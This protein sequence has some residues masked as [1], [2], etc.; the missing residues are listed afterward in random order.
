MAWKKS[1]SHQNYIKIIVIPLTPLWYFFD[2]AL[3]LLFYIIL[4]KIWYYFDII[5]IITI[6]MSTIWYYNDIIL[7]WLLQ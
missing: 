7:I 4:I 5:I 2:I 6:L 3:I 1:F